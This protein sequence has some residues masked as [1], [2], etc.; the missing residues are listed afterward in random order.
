[1]QRVARAAEL[2]HLVEAGNWEGVVVAAAKF[3]AS[4]DT[5]T[6]GSKGSRNSQRSQKSSTS[7]STRKD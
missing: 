5:S 6:G 7:C 1:M 2:N 4:E 3:E